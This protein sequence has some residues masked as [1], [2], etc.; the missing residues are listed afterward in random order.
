M[1]TWTVFIT[2]VSLAMANDEYLYANDETATAVIEH[3]SDHDF[4]KSSKPR[5]VEFY[6]PVSLSLCI[7]YIAVA[8]GKK[9]P[10]FQSH[11][12]SPSYL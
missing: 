4:E 9:W 1:K 12:S 5:L 10:R 8:S 2:L 7:N 11:N 3:T 6:S